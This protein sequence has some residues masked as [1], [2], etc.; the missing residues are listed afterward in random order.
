MRPIE[1]G[2]VKA[3]WLAFDVWPTA[4]EDGEAYELVDVTWDIILDVVK[5]ARQLRRADGE[6]TVFIFPAPPP[7]MRV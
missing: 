2:N 5:G 3:G 6:S 4:S 1:V 7:I